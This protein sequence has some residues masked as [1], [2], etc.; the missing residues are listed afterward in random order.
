MT[1]NELIAAI[2]KLRD[3]HEKYRSSQYQLEV[4]IAEINNLTGYVEDVSPKRV[5]S[6]HFGEVLSSLLRELGEI[7]AR[8]DK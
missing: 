7:V 1:Q 8:G 6:K 5:E 3:L 2:T 4:F